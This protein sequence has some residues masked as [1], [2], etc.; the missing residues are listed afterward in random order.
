MDKVLEWLNTAVST[1]NSYLA[2]YILIVLLV[3]VGLY[4]TIRIC[5]IRVS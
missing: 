2:D 4:F 3:G 1:V 5:L